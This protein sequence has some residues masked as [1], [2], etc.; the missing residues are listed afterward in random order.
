VREKE[1]ARLKRRE[2]LAEHPFYNKTDELEWLCQV[3]KQHYT[4]KDKSSLFLAPTIEN[5]LKKYSDKIFSS[6]RPASQQASW[7]R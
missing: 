5:I 7:K 3:L 6:S 1:K 2:F 4:T